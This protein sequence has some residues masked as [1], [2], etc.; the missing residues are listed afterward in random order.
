MIDIAIIGAGPA[1]LTAAIYAVRAGYKTTV[2]EKNFSGGQMNFTSEI[3]NFPGFLKISG[4]DLAIKMEEQAKKLGVE[5]KNVEIKAI[6]KENGTFKIE[7]SSENFEAKKIILSL[8]ATS[9]TLGIESEQKLRGMGV[10]YCATCDGGFFKG[11]EVAVVGGGNTAFEDAVYLSRIC[12][13]VYIIHRRDSFRADQILQE[14]AKTIEN[15]EFVV[16][17]VVDEIVGKFEVNAVKV[18]NTQ[19]NEEKEIPVSGVFIAIGTKPNSELVEGLVEKDEY[20]Y[21]I[22]D[23]NMRTSI[24]GIYAIGDVRNTN[25]RQIITA[26][27]DGAIAVND[28]VTR[29]A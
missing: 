3:E 5:F 26:C 1:G 13:K 12:K 11:A 27:A 2:F 9:K 6:N 16:N 25:L 24:D 19:S 8:G 10:S 21:I 4:S 15:I 28:I 23:N 18:K 22:T 20:G 17:S 29:K 14:E 7:T